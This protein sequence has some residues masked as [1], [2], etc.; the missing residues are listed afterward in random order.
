MRSD[1]ESHSSLPKGGQT[2]QKNMYGR[3]LTSI[4]NMDADALRKALTIKTISQPAPAT[5]SPGTLRISEN[6]NF[7]SSGDLPGSLSKRERLEAE[8]LHL[9]LRLSKGMEMKHKIA[10][11][12][13]EARM[14]RQR[15]AQLRRDAK[16]EDDEYRAQAA[17][18]AKDV[19]VLQ[20]Q[21]ERVVE[22]KSTN[23]PPSTT[24]MPPVSSATLQI[25][26][27]LLEELCSQPR[28]RDHRP[29]SPLKLHVCVQPRWSV[30]KS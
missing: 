21:S 22:T 7:S 24:S 30:T 6:D 19:Y 13:E 25:E 4:L 23:M 17:N 11:L 26:D 16:Q 20:S 18:I 8:L 3:R 1:F 29:T 15:T 9:K 10:A 12:N 5:L 14:A 2:P 28:A 27:R